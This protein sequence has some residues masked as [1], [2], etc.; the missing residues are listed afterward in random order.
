[1]N[2]GVSYSLYAVSSS[3]EGV[4]GSTQNL[5]ARL[6]ANPASLVY[7]ATNT[8]GPHVADAARSH[9]RWGPGSWPMAHNIEQD[10]SFNVQPRFNAPCHMHSRQCRP[11]R[12]GPLH[13]PPSP[14]LSHRF[15]FRSSYRRLKTGCNPH[16]RCMRHWGRTYRP[17][18]LEADACTKV[19]RIKVPKYTSTHHPRSHQQAK[20]SQKKNT[21]SYPPPLLDINN[22]ILCHLRSYVSIRP[23]RFGKGEQTVDFGAYIACCEDDF[24]VFDYFFLKGLG[25]FDFSVC[26]GE[27]GM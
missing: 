22:I 24:F 17:R 12:N 14:S 27:D 3:N 9:H 19:Q 4:R 16:R 13:L 23:R 6:P 15:R 8:S 1:M 26:R 21:S 10:P 25:Y 11:R 5:I 2:A 18:A 7:Q 20:V